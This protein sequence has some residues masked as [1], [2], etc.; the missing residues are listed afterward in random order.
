[1]AF[2]SSGNQLALAYSNRDG[3]VKFAKLNSDLSWA[4]STVDTA[5]VIGYCCLKFDLETPIISY[6]TRS[7]DLLPTGQP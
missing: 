5:Q 1:M 2:S 6:Y 7:F 4:I 3:E